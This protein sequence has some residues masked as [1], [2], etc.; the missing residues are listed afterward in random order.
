ML[1]QPS[2]FHAALG[3]AL[4]CFRLFVSVYSSGNSPIAFT[5]NL[6]AETVL[7]I[8]DMGENDLS[9]GLGLRLAP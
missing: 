5:R 8:L 9:G 6:G 7:E 2:G 4:H 1:I 3:T